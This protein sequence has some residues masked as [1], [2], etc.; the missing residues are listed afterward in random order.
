MWAEGESKLRGCDVVQIK[1]G[2]IVAGG[3]IRARALVVRQ[4]TGRPVQFA[5]SVE[6]RA[7]LRAWLERRSVRLATRQLAPPASSRRRFQPR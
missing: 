6:T 2:D 4:K 5:L 7:S 3:D 1:I